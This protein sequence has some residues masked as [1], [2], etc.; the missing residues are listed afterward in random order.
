MTTSINPCRPGLGASCSFCCGSHNFTLSPEKIEDLFINRGS[1]RNSPA[2][3]HPEQNCEEKLVREGMQC[4]HIGIS[5]SEP[6][7]ICCLVYNDNNRGAGLDSF[8]RGTCRHFRCPAFTYLSD[9]EVLFAAGLTSD[10]YYYSLLI[11]SIETVK[12][13]YAEYGMP[14]NVPEGML[15]DIKEDLVQNLLEDDMI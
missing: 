9:Q 1:R 12:E 4:P 5:E 13:L 14:E 11:N 10:W 2:M 7:I 6:S 15:I 8:F 3:L